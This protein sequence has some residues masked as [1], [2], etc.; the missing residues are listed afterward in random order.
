MAGYSKMPVKI[1]CQG[2]YSADA[3][4]RKQRR[5]FTGR[6]FWRCGV[7]D[8]PTTSKNT[9]TFRLTPGFLREYASQSEREK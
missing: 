5:I 9:E 4:A 7:E 3:L 8:C 6:T 2:E 1:L